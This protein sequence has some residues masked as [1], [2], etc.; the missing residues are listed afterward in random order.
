VSL[1]SWRELEY[2]LG[3]DRRSLKNL[4]AKAPRFYEPFDVVKKTGDGLRHIDNP[5]GILKEIQRKIYR[6]LLR[7]HEMPA[8]MIGGVTGRSVRQNAFCHVG[9]QTLVKLDL[10]NHFGRITNAQVLEAL[11]R[12]LG[13]S[14]EIARVVT[15][16]TTVHSRLPQ[17]APTSS[18]LANLVVLPAHREISS[19]AER[20]AISYT[21]FVDDLTISGSRPRD[22]LQS[23]IRILQRHQFAVAMKK[24][25]ILDRHDR[26]ETTGLVVNR[27]VSVGRAQREQIR[28]DLLRFARVKAMSLQEFSSIWGRIRYVGFIHAE[29]GKALAELAEAV[30]P[31]PSERP[32]IGLDERRCPCVDTARHRYKGSPQGRIGDAKS[33]RVDSEPHHVSP[34]FR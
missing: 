23:V 8:N 5:S 25:H 12:E 31:V 7:D 27:E 16:L 2:L 30:L 21:L 6:K 28:I 26:Q 19:L 3:T 4:A 22:I 32:Y 33:E 20:Y 15:Q 17:G 29:H 18:M 10:R 34:E 13:L 24:L 1:L 14:T 11:R 9:H